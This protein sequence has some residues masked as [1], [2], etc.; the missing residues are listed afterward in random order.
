MDAMLETMLARLAA[1]SLQTLLLAALVWALCR[2]WRRLPAA[3]QCWLWWLVALQALVGL[4]APGAVE[5]PLLP[6]ARVEAAVVPALADAAPAAAAAGFGWASALAALWLAGVLLLVL[7]TAFAFR[8][9]RHLLR[10]SRPCPDA[11]LTAALRMAAEAHGLRRAP[12]L[13]ISDGIESPQLVGPWRPVLLLPAHRLAAMADD[14]LDMALTH[15]LVHLCRRDLWLGLVPALAQHLFFFHPALH[16]AAHEYGIAR[17]AACDAAVVAGNRHC[18]QHYGRLL[19]QL[20]VA[21]RAAAGLA[22]ASPSFVSLKRRLL[23]LQ[24]MPTVPGWGARLLLVAVAVAAIVPLRLVATPVPPAPPAA[25]APPQPPAQPAAPAAVPVPAP[26]PAP[27]PVASPQPPAPPTGAPGLLQRIVDS[28][29]APAGD[30][31][32]DEGARREIRRAIADARREAHA[33]VLAELGDG[34]AALAEGAGELSEQAVRLAL[35]EVG[36][37]LETLGPELRQAAEQAR[38]AG[39]EAGRAQVAAAHE[40]RQALASARAAM[41]AE[42]AARRQAEAARR[43]A[44][45]SAEAARARPR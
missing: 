3:S 10:A 17:E 11:R 14:D 27:A 40:Q 4:F 9:S 26:T 2:V 35:R 29:P 22:S 5:L 18:R 32:L 12:S 25:V 8:A 1:T 45:I 13:R 38:L 16:L 6:A 24:H 33:A 7:R 19:V 36:R 44:E 31:W 15:E 28:G 39:I 37:G 21:P 30:A 43:A 23:M 41:R 34:H 20:G 42:A